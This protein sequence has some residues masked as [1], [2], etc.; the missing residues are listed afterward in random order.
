MQPEEREH[1]LSLVNGIEQSTKKIRGLRAYLSH[2][3]K[4]KELIG[5]QLEKEIK[6]KKYLEKELLKF[7]REH[8]N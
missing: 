1:W 8:K 5:Q 3:K 6:K 2:P 7:K 4:D